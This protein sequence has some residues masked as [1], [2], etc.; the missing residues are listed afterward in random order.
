MT[1]ACTEPS[2]GNY[3]LVPFDKMSV[4]D[5]TI[6]GLF[7]RPSTSVEKCLGQ[8]NDNAPVSQNSTGEEETSHHAT[9]IFTFRNINNRTD[10][11]APTR[12]QPPGQH[13]CTQYVAV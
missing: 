5:M 10:F 3:L 7:P 12:F 11:T 13:R 9:Y 1:R 8:R 2:K 4:F 6:T